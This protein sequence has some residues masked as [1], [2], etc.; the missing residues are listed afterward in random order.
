MK[1]KTLILIFAFFMNLSLFS[2]EVPS[3]GEMFMDLPARVIGAAGFVL[4]TGIFVAASPF[5]LINLAY[6]GSAEGIR[7]AGKRLVIT[8]FLYTFTRGTGDYPGYMEELEL[9]RE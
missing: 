4:G 2:K 5:M 1:T 8:P 6:T 9:V 3:T 7:G